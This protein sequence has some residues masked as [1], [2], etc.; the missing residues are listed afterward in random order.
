[1][2]RQIVIY[3]VHDALVDADR[4]HTRRYSTFDEISALM[5]HAACRTLLIR[6]HELHGS[7]VAHRDVPMEQ[8]LDFYLFLTASS[9]F[10][11]A[12]DDLY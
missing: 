12:L 5:K 7:I 6:F 1:M 9:S 8:P 2:L 10:F 3:R 11:P 4:C